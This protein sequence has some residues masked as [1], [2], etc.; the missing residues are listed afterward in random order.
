MQLIGLLEELQPFV[1]NQEVKTKLIYTPDEGIQ[2]TFG[3]YDYRLSIKCKDKDSLNP[4]I[5]TLASILTFIPQMSSI[6]IGNGKYEVLMPEGSSYDV[7]SKLTK[8]EALGPL[9][10]SAVSDLIDI[11]WR[12]TDE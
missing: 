10:Q 8:R 11:L 2:L 4:V 1:S 9:L 6:N 7:F 5:D 3:D 12:Y